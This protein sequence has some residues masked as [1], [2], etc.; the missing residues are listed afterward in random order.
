MN[1]KL[2]EKAL[3]ATYVTPS[4]I[5]ELTDAANAIQ[6]C[7]K[8][9]KLGY[10]SPHSQEL[11]DELVEIGIAGYEHTGNGIFRYYLNKKSK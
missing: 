4:K 10:F 3:I 9:N 7:Q 11:M 1:N 8:F 6:A 5:R 2:I